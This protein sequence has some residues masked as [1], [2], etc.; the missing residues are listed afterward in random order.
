MDDVRTEPRPGPGSLLQIAGFGG[1]MTFY[2]LHL[3]TGPPLVS[4]SCGIGSTWPVH[5]ATGIAFAG[6]VASGGVA[7]WVLRAA[8]TSGGDE[9]LRLR[10][11]LLG[12]TGLMLNVLAL[13]VVLWSDIPSHVL[14]PCLP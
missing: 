14:N 10:R 12:S 3:L 2:A 6:I 1:G 7:W 8:G 11:Q 4:L 13:I 9:A 5:L